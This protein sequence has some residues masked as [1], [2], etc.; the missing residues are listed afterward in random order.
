MAYVSPSTNIVLIKNCILQKSDN[1]ETDT[2][3]FANITAQENYFRDLSNKVTYSPMT[4][5]NIKQGVMRIGKNMKELYG[6]NYMYFMNS[7]TVTIDGTVYTNEVFENKTYYCF[8]DEL[9]YINNNCTEVYYSIDYIQ[10]FMFDFTEKTS[11]V[12]RLTVE[13]DVIG[14]YLLDEGLNT[15]EYVVERVQ[16]KYFSQW[17]YLVAYGSMVSLPQNKVEIDGTSVNKY[18]V[19]IGTKAGTS[20]GTPFM[21]MYF[22]E[23][24]YSTTSYLMN[25]T[26]PMKLIVVTGAKVYEVTEPVSAIHAKVNANFSTY[27]FG[28]STTLIPLPDGANSVTGKDVFT[29]LYCSN[30]VVDATGY[31]YTTTALNNSNTLFSNIVNVMIM[32][33]ELA[34]N[35]GNYYVNETP[36]LKIVKPNKSYTENGTTH[37]GMSQF[38]LYTPK[39]KKLFTYPYTYFIVS[40]TDGNSQDYR[41]ELFDTQISADYAPFNFTGCGLPS[42][43]ACLYP[44][45]YNGLHSSRGYNIYDE[46]WIVYSGNAYKALEYGVILSNFPMFSLKVDEYKKYMEQNRYR[47][48]LDTVSAILSLSSSVVSTAL[49]PSPTSIIGTASGVVDTIGKFQNM[50]NQREMAKRIPDSFIGQLGT[51][52]LAVAN[53]VCGFRVLTMRIKEEN[54]RVID[55]YFTRYGY[56]ISHHLD[57]NE[58]RNI[59]PHFTFIKT[60]ECNLSVKNMCMSQEDEK[61]IEAI[62]NRGIRYW[63]NPTEYKNYSVDNSVT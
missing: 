61:A 42:P 35:N 7:N 16:T 4:Y 51:S 53:G 12:E 55:D 57:L 52:D 18:G 59:R 48:S 15:G 21:A 63:N 13:Q 43:I 20:S 8:I 22:F 49:S 5:Q 50:A 14:Q 58:K 41:F 11:L 29:M 37:D 25:G 47:D 36:T 6:C 28:N 45:D 40:S 30:A 39:N 32:P 34:P 62:Y 31:S 56:K 17:R 26:V 10:T 23:L 24:V 54:A 46:N 3:Y 38:G 27:D 2:L 60:I 33:S 1:D 19:F 44:K 9:K